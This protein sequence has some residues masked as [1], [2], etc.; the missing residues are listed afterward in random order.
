MLR[1]VTVSL[2]N[3]SNGLRRSELEPSIFYKCSKPNSKNSNNKSSFYN[4]SKTVNSSV[5]RAALSHITLRWIFNNSKKLL[6]NNRIR[7][8]NL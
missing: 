8:R 3:N 1:F 4:N 2:S 5:K 7:R 6:I